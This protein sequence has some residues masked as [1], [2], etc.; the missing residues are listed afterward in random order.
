MICAGADPPMGVRP[1]NLSMMI[2][3]ME[4]FPATLS[5]LLADIPNQDAR[6]KP[7]TGAWS[8]L[9]ILRHLGDE[10]VDDFRARVRSTLEDPARPWSPIDPETWARDRRYN[11]DDPAEALDRFACE[12]AASIA[13]LRTL[14]NPDWSLTYAHPKAGPIAAG[15]LMLSWAAHDALHLRQ[16]SKRIYELTLRDAPKFSADYAGPW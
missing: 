4:R 2:D 5:T 1:V 6:F 13:W 11:D 10:E 7:Q 8:I 12:R 14:A 15:D 16:I 9:E 3:R